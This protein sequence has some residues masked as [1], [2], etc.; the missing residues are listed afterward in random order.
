MRAT[1]I[2]GGKIEDYNYIKKQIELFGSDYI[3]CADSGYNH[4]LKMGLNVNLL[5]GD[6]D[7]L[8]NIPEKI[9]T[10]RYPAEKNMTDTEIALS[11]AREAGAK[12]ILFIGVTGTRIDHMLTNILLLKNCIFN[13]ENAVIIDEY[14][15]MKI[16]ETSLELSGEKGDIVSLVPIN[17]CG[18]VTTQGLYYPLENAV[19]KTGGSLGVSNVMTGEKANVSLESGTLI[20]IIARD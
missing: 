11:H 18:G 17:D 12:D 10:V 5:V 16:T 2:S 15:K 4:A 20:V 1:I 19:L 6:F 3:I 14:N 13:N 7:S 9:K 8:N